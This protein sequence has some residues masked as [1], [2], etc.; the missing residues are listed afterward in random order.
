[1]RRGDARR[2]AAHGAINDR[3]RAASRN[4]LGS[5]RPVAEFREVM[6]R[7]ARNSL[8]N[9]D[10]CHRFDVC[11]DPENPRRFFLY[12]LYR[13]ADA[14]QVH[15]DSPHFRDFDARVRTWVE[16]KSVAAWSRLPLRL[17]AD[18]VRGAS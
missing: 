1:M 6:L 3:L 2:T 9:E 11:T 17:G 12:E 13:D 16:H 5:T 10:G 7:Q 14:F 4:G 18:D 15:L 8:A